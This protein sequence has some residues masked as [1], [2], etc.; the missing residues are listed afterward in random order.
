MT[1]VINGIRPHPQICCG[2]ANAD[3]GLYPDLGEDA[4]DMGPGA[5][6]AI[7]VHAWNG[8]GKETGW[9]ASAFIGGVLVGIGE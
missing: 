2:G 5:P 9:G 6:T 3:I 7:V 1:S 4:G 8:L